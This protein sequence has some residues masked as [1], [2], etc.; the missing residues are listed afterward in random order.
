[1]SRK[2][3]NRRGP[4]QGRPKTETDYRHSPPVP[5]NEWEQASRDMIGAPLS[6]AEERN[7]AEALKRAEQAAHL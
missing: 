3:V 5:L 6:E 4:S 2:A 1:M 7:R